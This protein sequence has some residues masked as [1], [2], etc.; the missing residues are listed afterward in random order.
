[1]LVSVSA[2]VPFRAVEVFKKHFSFYYT[3]FNINIP[4]EVCSYDQTFSTAAGD[5][6]ASGHTAAMSNNALINIS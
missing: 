6:L 2:N 1:M 3:S 4:S 5:M